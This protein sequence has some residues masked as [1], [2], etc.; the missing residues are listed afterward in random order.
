MH[1]AF[2][3]ISIRQS[4]GSYDYLGQTA[5]EVLYKHFAKKEYID[6]KGKV[7]DKLRVVLKNNILELPEEYKP[8]AVAI[9]ALCKKVSGSL[10]IKNQADKKKVELNKQVFLS[11]EFKELWEKIKYKTTYSVHFDS[12]KLIEKCC[13]EIQTSLVVS[14]PKLVYTKAGLENTIAGVSAKER[15]RIAVHAKTVDEYLPDIIT[16]LQNKTNLTRKTIV[17]I[18]VKSNNL[19]LFKKNPQRYMEEVAQIITSNMRMMVVDGIKYTKLGDNEYYAQELFENQELNGY[20][21]KNMIESKKSVYHFIVYDSNNE[22]SFA[23]SFENNQSVKLYAKLPDWFKIQTPLGSYNPD[24]AVLIEK[25]G[26]DK[27]YFV[28]ETKSNLLFETLRPTES[29]KIECGRRH[30]AAMGQGAV[31]EATA[32]F[33]EFMEKERS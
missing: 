30:F 20:L 24:W 26:K 5:S 9:G 25:D 21:S 29:A 18:L 7:Q 6:D 31:F 23:Q 22:E 13:T 32:N 11:P 1:L 3:N 33:E 8:C 4:D 27:L 14:S 15:N 16:Y 19:Y 12:A 10:D 28:I 2:A 17:D